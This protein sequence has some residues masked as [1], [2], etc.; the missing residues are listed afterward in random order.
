MPSMNQT[1]RRRPGIALGLVLASLLGLGLW[2]MAADPDATAPSPDT[3]ATQDDAQPPSAPGAGAP[4]ATIANPPL[5]EPGP[6]GVAVAPPALEGAE[7]TEP[8]AAARPG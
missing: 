6:G 8:V 1:T 5:P 3:V 2:R 7:P 4:A